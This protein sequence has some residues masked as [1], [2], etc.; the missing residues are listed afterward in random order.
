LASPGPHTHTTAVHATQIRSIPCQM[1]VDKCT[2]TS[3]PHQS[4]MWRSET[5]RTMRRTWRLAAHCDP[6]LM[7]T[8][9]NKNSESTHSSPNNTNPFIVTMPPASVPWIRANVNPLGP[10]IKNAKH[11]TLRADNVRDTASNDGQTSPREPHARLLLWLRTC[12]G[13]LVVSRVANQA[14]YWYGSESTTW[15]TPTPC[16]PVASYSVHI[17]K[18]IDLHSDLYPQKHPQSMHTPVNPRSHTTSQARTQPVFSGGGS[19]SQHQH[20]DSTLDKTQRQTIK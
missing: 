13:R 19:L 5:R 9:A 6:V 3:H 15:T 18:P 2:T 10:P 14:K 11:S 17:Y 20:H 12:G 8:A 1:N 7:I 16:G 4:H